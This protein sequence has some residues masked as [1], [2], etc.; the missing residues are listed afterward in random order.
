MKTMYIC[1]M[2]DGEDF[3][4]N[5]ME[6]IEKAYENLKSGFDK[7]DMQPITSCTFFE[8]SSSTG[9]LVKKTKQAIVIETYVRK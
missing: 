6:S 7:E 2:H 9:F 8:L 5:P 1:L 3:L 4:S